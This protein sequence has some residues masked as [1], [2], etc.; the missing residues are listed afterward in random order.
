[1][2]YNLL[3]CDEDLSDLERNKLYIDEFSAKMNIHTRQYCHQEI[4]AKVEY[5]LFKGSIDI[6]FLDVRIGAAD[7]IEFAKKLLTKNPWMIIIFIT[8]YP[9]FAKQ[10]YQMQ[11]FGYMQ[12]PV[13]KRQ[14]EWY[15]IKAV[16]LCE[17]IKYK[18]MSQTI[19]VKLNRKVLKI[20]Q[21]EINYVEKILRKVIIHTDHRTYEVYDSMISIAEQLNENFVRINQGAIVKIDEIDSIQKNTVFLRTGE[22]FKIG[23]T[24]TKQVKEICFRRF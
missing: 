22:D 16:Y 8:S 17:M 3:I 6:A 11:A 23:R 5:L 2:D 10:A 13:D 18:S 21:S 24:Y 19:T 9:D 14:L 7:G 1:M 12:K 15:F 4:D 20:R